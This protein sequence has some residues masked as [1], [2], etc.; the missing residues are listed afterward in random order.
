MKKL[1][2]R[3]ESVLHEKE[4]AFFGS[5]IKEI[6]T[7]EN[8]QQPASKPIVPN[9]AVKQEPVPAKQSQ[10]NYMKDPLFSDMD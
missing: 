1:R 2:R 5:V 3:K 4:A 10:L 8:Q 9:V 6:N 7:V